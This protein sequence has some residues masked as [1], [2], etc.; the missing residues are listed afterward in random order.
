MGRRGGLER[1]AEG[2]AA[3]PRVSRD[4]ALERLSVLR[5]S[6][7]G[8]IV[9]TDEAGRG[10]LAGPVVAAAVSLTPVQEEALLSL[11]L[12][13]SKKLTAR[14]REYGRAFSK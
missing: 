4:E 9:G 13:D 10:P 7:P 2:R 1:W 12:R 3:R 8:A 5:S 6:G 14:A 11:G